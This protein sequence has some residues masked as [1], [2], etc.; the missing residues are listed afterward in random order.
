MTMKMG[1]I[2]YPLGHTLSPVFQQAALDHLKIDARFE[3][4]PTPPDRL[5]ATVESFRASEFLGVCVTLPHK[6]AV[7]PMLDVIDDTARQIGAV[8]WI[9]NRAGRL[10]GHNTDAPGFL[11]SLKEEARFEPS[12]A[13]A[14]IFGAGGAARAVAFA[15]R[16][17]GVARLTIA[18][19]T[20]EKARDLA[21][22][23]SRGRFKPQ[24]IGISRDEL[25]DVAP[26][27]NLLVN[28]T[29]IGMA[30]G[31]APDESPVPAEL[32]S[33]NAL[34][35][36]AVYAPVETPFI[37]AVEKAGGRGASGLTMLVYQG[38]EGF[39]LC[40]GKDAPVR[41]MLAA[42]KKARGIK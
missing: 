16:E 41:V 1:I 32:V 29:S 15:L 12:G 11:R 40:T 25:A 9:I 22:S 21:A 4:W 37:R 33:A 14:L 18:N 36:D 3:A 35:Y 30:G 34:G 26:Y 2:G 31:P 10:H 27:C 13:N 17:A 42:V 20:V 19:R 23:M 8:N 24:A 6:Q 5:Q 39:K 38:A 28:T 7:M